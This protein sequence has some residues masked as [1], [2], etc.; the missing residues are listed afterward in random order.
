[1]AFR[2]YIICHAV[3]LIVWGVLLLIPFMLTKN[4]FIILIGMI[5]MLV[6]V[7]CGLF[8]IFSY[9]LMNKLF[10]LIYYI[11]LIIEIVLLLINIVFLILVIVTVPE[12]IFIVLIGLAINIPLTVVFCNAAAGA[13]EMR[14]GYFGPHRQAVAVKINMQP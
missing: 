9:R 3:T 7:T 11:G 5:R 14:M 10:A 4:I 8:G 6:P 2:D 13:R 1:M 12:A